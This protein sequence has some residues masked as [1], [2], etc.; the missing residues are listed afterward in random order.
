MTKKV[1]ILG[2]L[3]TWTHAAALKGYDKWNEIVPIDGIDNVIAAVEAGKVD[4]GV[5]P[6]ENK[7]SGEIAATYAGIYQRDVTVIDK[8]GLPI[9]NCLA[10]L[11][12]GLSVDRINRFITKPEAYAQT[13]VWRSKHMPAVSLVPWD[14]TA[15]GMMEIRDKNLRDAA[16]LG[17][18]IAAD[19]YNLAVLARDIDDVADNATLFS[20][21]TG[22]RKVKTQ[23]EQGKTY[24][25]WL[26]MMPLQNVPGELYRMLTPIYKHGLDMTKIS[27][28][29]HLPMYLPGGYLFEIRIKGH[30]AE[31]RVKSALSALEKQCAKEATKLVIA[32]SY[33]L[34]RLS[35]VR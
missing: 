35:D 8:I 33:P 15:G 19:H 27:S 26:L 32:G 7:I 14:S 5:V 20:V 16:G 13:G 29:E 28:I 9:R 22:G 23:P 24:E 31:P 34:V 25:T 12:T 3:L 2:P 1:G 11:P 21:I 4:E 17:P 30:A 18:E 10:V 6:E